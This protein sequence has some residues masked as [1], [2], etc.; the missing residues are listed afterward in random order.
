MK[1]VLLIVIVIALGAYAAYTLFVKKD[2]APDQPKPEGLSIGK[3]SGDFRESL[4]SLMS[5]YFSLK[6][7]LVQSDTMSAN[8]AAIR[9]ARASDSLQ[10]DQIAGDSTGV[11]RETAKNFAGTIQGSA[12]ALSLEKDLEAKR[13]E[14]EMI[15]DALWSLARTVKYEGQKVYYQFCPMAFNNRG[16]YW[17]SQNPQIQNPYFGDK[18]LTCGSNRDSISYKGN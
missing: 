1:R 7:A 18:M 16:A 17:V 3:Q 10:T 5:A 8:N 15:S 4:D 9:L 11:I 6:D 2:D 14:F 12:H 13:L